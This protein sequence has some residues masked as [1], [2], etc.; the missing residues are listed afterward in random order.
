M[1]EEAFLKSL[2]EK[3]DDEAT[4]LVYADWL[5][6][7]GQDVQ[8]EY[9]RLHQ[10]ARRGPDRMRQLALQLDPKWVAS[11]TGGRAEGQLVVH[12]DPESERATNVTIT[13][14]SA[15]HRAGESVVH[16][17]GEAAS[18]KKGPVNK[19]R[20]IEGVVRDNRGVPIGR[21]RCNWANFPLRVSFQLSI[22]LRSTHSAPDAV[23]L[24][25][26]ESF[27]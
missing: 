1:T 23:T 6:E 21:E 8:S 9:L 3:P 14:A 7:R 22:T 15:F 4:L 2:L 24:F 17:I 26:S 25:P 19:Y 10:Q 16:V 11:V 27:M 12:R 13:S 18:L 5:E 20:Q